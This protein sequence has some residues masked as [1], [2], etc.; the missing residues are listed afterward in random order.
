MDDGATGGKLPC[1]R[2]GLV[3]TGG[4]CADTGVSLGGGDASGVA[5]C[6]GEGEDRRAEYMFE[7]A[8]CTGSCSSALSPWLSLA[9]PQERSAQ[10]PATAGS[11]GGRVDTAMDRLS[12]CTETMESSTSKRSLVPAA[13]WPALVVIRTS[14]GVGVLV[15]MDGVS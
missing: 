8:P 12:A 4:G 13:A 6:G 9:S 10:L 7:S 15:G 2:P 11:D 14:K 1:G 3:G 5:G